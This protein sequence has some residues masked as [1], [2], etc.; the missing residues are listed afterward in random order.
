MADPG[1]DEL[2]EQRLRDIE[3]RAAESLPE[4][5]LVIYSAFALDGDGL[6]LD[7]LDDVAVAGRCIFMQKHN[8]F[9]GKGKDFVSA[10]FN[11]PTWL[12]LCAVA[13]DMILVTGDQHHVFLEG[14]TVLREENGIKVVEFE[15]GS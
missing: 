11:S 4:E 15:M 3:E 9:F 10:E 7:N 13:N 1:K 6:P 12:Q 5:A 8:P 2:F 14:V